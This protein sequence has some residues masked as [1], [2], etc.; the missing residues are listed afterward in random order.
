ME[1]C[2][3]VKLKEIANIVAGQSP[4]SEFYTKNIDDTP[5]LQGNRTF[6]YKY[7]L[8]DTYT[9]KITKLAKPG[10]VLM[11]VRAP[12]GDINITKNVVCVGRGLNVLDAKDGDNEFLYYALKA[13]IPNIVKK[14]N[15]TTYDSISTDELKEIE[16]IIPKNDNIRKKISKILGNIDKQIERNNA[17]VHKLQCFE[18]ALIFSKK[19]G[20]NYAC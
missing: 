12:V 9:K 1:K 4:K 14:G 2:N 10:Q 8:I 13:N 11:S 7:P 20:I 17:M 6:G 3:K 5:F 16:I 18:Q 19:W 15:G